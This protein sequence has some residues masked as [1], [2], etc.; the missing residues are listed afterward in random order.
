MGVSL[1][2]NLKT[3]LICFLS[4]FSSVTVTESVSASI[5]DLQVSVNDD[6]TITENIDSK[7]SVKP[8]VYD[9]ITLAESVTADVS[10]PQVD[11]NDSPALTENIGASLPDD[12]EVSIYDSASLTESATPH[13]AFGASVADSVSVSEYSEGV[14]SVVPSVSDDVSVSESVDV[15]VRL[16]SFVVLEWVQVLIED[17]ELA[18]SVNDSVSTAEDVS[19][20]IALVGTVHDSVSTTE[21]TTL[22]VSAPSPSIYDSIS[23][24]ENVNLLISSDQD[25]SVS[26]DVSISENVQGDVGALVDYI[27]WK[28]KGRIKVVEAA[29]ESALSVDVSDSV[30]TS[31]ST[32]ADLEITPSTISDTIAIAE[33]TDLKLS[34]EIDVND[35]TSL[36]ENTDQELATAT[37]VNDGVTCAESASVS[38]TIPKP[39]V[40][41]S[42]S[43]AENVQCEVG[44]IA[45]F[46][47]SKMMLLGV[48]E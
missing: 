16:T 28:S 30:T 40:Y 46:A 9:A 26:E 24:S 33:S 17:V 34:Y 3:L 6:V 27:Y 2:E 39:N 25:I 20:E 36:A 42:V 13:I 48:S 11:V 35:S 32:S 4:V 14:E 21:S 31:E 1:T 38:I 5:S 43:V 23:A 7:T 45:Q 12:L 15:T 10:D 37:N 22:A 29:P 18:I 44:G 8:S 41:E 47:P 19:E